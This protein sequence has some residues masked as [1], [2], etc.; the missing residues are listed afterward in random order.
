MTSKHLRTRWL[1]IL[2]LGALVDVGALARLGAEPGVVVQMEGDRLSVSAQGV[3][4][5]DI[6]AEIGRATNIKISGEARLDPEVIN[7]AQTVGFR[8]L[9]VEEAFRRLLPDHNF[10]VVHSSDGIEIEI[11]AP[12][13]AAPPAPQGTRSVGQ[14][15]PSAPPAAPSAPIAKADPAT[16]RDTALSDPDPGKRAQAL[17][18]LSQTPDK[19]IAGETALS[20][21]DRDREPAVL[22]TALD[23]LR[24]QAPVRLDPLIRFAGNSDQV[25][26]LRVRAIELLRDKALGDGQVQALLRVA[27]AQDRSEAV[28]AVARRILEDTGIR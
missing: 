27:A 21:L 5:K 2:I 24:G 23:A 3:P 1:A 11:H 12:G 18:L 17:S 28:Q 22:R 4:V 16:L 6:V 25:P 13:Q 14:A 10:V 8:D 19:G 20:V 9:S 26:E 15:A 7:H